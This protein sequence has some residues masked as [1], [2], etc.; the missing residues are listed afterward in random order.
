MTPDQLL[1]FAT[2]AD[3]G[4]IS[5]AA[6]QL[7]LSQPAVSGQLRALQEWFGEPCL[8]YTSGLCPAIGARGRGGDHRG[9]QPADAGAGRDR[10][11]AHGGHRR[12]LGLG[13]PD[14]ADVYK[15]Q[16]LGSKP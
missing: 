13:R 16:E 7:H 3:A 9:P 6:Q 8:S 10:D 4:N 2:V 1:T 15:R 5:R 12:G 11:R 14:A